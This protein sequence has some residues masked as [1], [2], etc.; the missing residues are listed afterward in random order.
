MDP[1]AY[2]VVRKLEESH[3][4]FVARRRILARLLDEALTGLD[5]AKTLDVGC[6]TGATMGFLGRYGEVTGIDVS[7]KAVEYCRELGSKRLCLASGE[8]LP[9]VDGSFDLVTALDLLEHLEHEAAGLREMWRVLK[10]DGRLLLVVPAFM[11][12]WSEFDRFSGHYRRYTG[13]ELKQ[14]AEEAGFEVARLSYFNTLLFPVIWGVRMVKNLMGGR[15]SASSDLDSPGRVL[16]GLLTWCFSLESGLIAR[17]Q[18]PFGVSLLCVAR[19]G[20]LHRAS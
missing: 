16:N 17:G 15:A 18:L 9:F 12:L 20:R 7:P 1:N 11:F 10:G 3:W 14:R 5:H 2:E 4:F 6:G 8:S 19:K 13:S